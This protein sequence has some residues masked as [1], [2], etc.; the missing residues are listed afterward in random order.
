VDASRLLS[1]DDADRLP[2]P[3]LEHMRHKRVH[4]GLSDFGVEDVLIE[5]EGQNPDLAKSVPLHHRLRI[6]LKREGR[7]R[8][9]RRERHHPRGA[10]VT[11]LTRKDVRASG[12]NSA[13]LPNRLALSLNSLGTP[14][15][16]RVPIG[17]GGLPPPPTRA[18]PCAG[19][20][21]DRRA[22]G[23]E[24]QGRRSRPVRNGLGCPFAE[25]RS[26]ACGRGLHEAFCV[27]SRTRPR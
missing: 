8:R 2:I 7:P 5:R 6:D 14:V 25:R 3:G 12:K 19:I 10:V 18:R 1:L 9:R 13:T 15:G 26:Y 20:I 4:P 16:V 24:R 23:V 21:P 22:H 11:L 17:S 27:R